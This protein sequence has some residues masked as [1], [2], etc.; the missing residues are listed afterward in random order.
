MSA[1]D[2]AGYSLSREAVLSLTARLRDEYGFAD[3]YY[4]GANIG[5]SEAFTLAP[6]ALRNDL[7]ALQS[8][9]LFILL[10]PG[11][12]VTSA[13]VETGFALARQIPCLLLVRD[14]GDLP[15]LLQQADRVGTSGILPPVRI[16]PLRG[17]DQ[18]AQEVA[19][20]RDWL[21]AGSAVGRR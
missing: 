12:L 17:P 19:A 3:I 10:Y 21:A 2:E 6:E 16:A 11:K 1:L 18:A 15:Y 20:F 14:K 13:L 9:Q 7:E 8:A 5:G 4:A